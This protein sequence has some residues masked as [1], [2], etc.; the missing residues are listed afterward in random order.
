MLS[1]GIQ[2][3]CKYAIK[4]LVQNV[5]RDKM[6]GDIAGLD[7]ATV[8][9]I[10]AHELFG[11]SFLKESAKSEVVHVGYENLTADDVLRRLMPGVSE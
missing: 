3:E 7:Q 4:E 9:A 5:V 2:S 6:N 11:R 1:Q 10:A 8:D